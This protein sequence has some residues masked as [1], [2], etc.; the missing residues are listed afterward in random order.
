MK[1]LLLT[2]TFSVL[3]IFSSLT[4][5]ARLAIFDDLWDVSQGTRITQAAAPWQE[6]GGQ[7]H[8]TCSGVPMARI[9]IPKI[10]LSSKTTSLKVMFIG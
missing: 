2:I 3:L 5:N 1:K 7:T 6:D 9:L 4:A 10:T 8:G